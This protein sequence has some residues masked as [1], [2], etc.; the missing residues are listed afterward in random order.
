MSKPTVIKRYSYLGEDF[1]RNLALKIFSLTEKEL[2]K[3][4]WR[5]QSGKRV[6]SL[7]GKITWWKIINGG[8]IPEKELLVKEKGKD[9]GFRVV[10][11][12]EEKV[13][14]GAIRNDSNLEYPWLS[15]YLEFKESLIS[16]EEKTKIEQEL[17]RKQKRERSIRMIDNFFETAKDASIVEKFS[18]GLKDAEKQVKDHFMEKVSIFS[19]NISEHSLLEKVRALLEGNA[20]DK[21]SYS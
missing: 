13:Y 5:Y 9:F 16:P 11:Y 17:Y 20:T 3:L 19:F 18:L 15:D 8:F 4:V 7:R 12:T 1:G 2:E 10:D 6:G 14:L 21:N